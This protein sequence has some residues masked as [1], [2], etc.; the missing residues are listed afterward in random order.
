MSEERATAERLL[1]LVVRT[2]FRAPGASADPYTDA[3]VLWLSVVRE[4]REAVSRSASL[5]EVERVYRD[6]VE[7]WLWGEPSIHSYTEDTVTAHHL[8]D[9]ELLDAFRAVCGE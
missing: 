1:T 7:S 6:A 5:W 8:D 4:A 9:D 2:R 3:L